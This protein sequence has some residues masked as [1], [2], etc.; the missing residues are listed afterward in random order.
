[1]VSDSLYLRLE[2]KG[3]GLQRFFTNTLHFTISVPCFPVRR[4]S[5]FG[6]VTSSP[7][8]SGLNKLEEGFGAHHTI[9]IIWT[10]Q[11]LMTEKSIQAIYTILRNLQHSI[12]DY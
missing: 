7:P 11:D 9:L 12:G 2:L 8:H 4:A 1:M 5:K 3:H 10:V 6:A